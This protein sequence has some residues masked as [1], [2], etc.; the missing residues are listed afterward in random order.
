MINIT[1]GEK[2]MKNFKE[3]DT[4]AGYGYEVDPDIA[5]ELGAFV[6]EAIDKEDAEEAIEE[7]G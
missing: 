1:I 3:L 5:E 6:E 2:L 4:T 7:E